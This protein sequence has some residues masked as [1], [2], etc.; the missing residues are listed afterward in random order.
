MK[1]PE[2]PATNGVS[3]MSLLEMNNVHFNKR[4]TV[5][6]PEILDSLKTHTTAAQNQD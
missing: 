3:Q 5:L 6:T 2:M 4:H 1:T